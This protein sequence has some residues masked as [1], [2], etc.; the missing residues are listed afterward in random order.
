[1]GTNS[2][3]KKPEVVGFGFKHEYT[4][5]YPTIFAPISCWYPL[6]YIFVP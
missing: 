3:A 4:I 6:R 5:L 2:K 1:M